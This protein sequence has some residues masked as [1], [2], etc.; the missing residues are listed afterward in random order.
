MNLKTDLS[1]ELDL[2]NVSYKDLFSLLEFI[3]TEYGY[4]IWVAPDWPYD[5]KIYQ[6]NIE[7]LEKEYKPYYHIG[8]Y[9]TPYEAC[10]DAI[11]F[12]IKNLL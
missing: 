6:Y 10:V 2:L 4:D 9:Q 1:N 3:R 7:N 11:K 8:E 5:K 12:T